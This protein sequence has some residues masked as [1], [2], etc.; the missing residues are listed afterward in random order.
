MALA[1][2][3]WQRTGSSAWVGAV[4]LASELGYIAATP[5]AGWL[6][7]RRDRRR[8][9]VGAELC[10]A[11]ISAA[12]V[13]PLPLPALV[14]LVGLASLERGAVR[15]GVAGSAADA[16]S[17][18][19]AW[20]APMRR[21]RAGAR[22]AFSPGP[23]VGG[24]GAAR[25]LGAELVFLFNSVSS[26]VCAAL[27]VRLACPAA[28]AAA[29]GDDAAHD[30]LLAGVRAIGRHPALRRICSAW[31]LARVGCAIEMTAA[32]V[33]GHE[34]G[35]GAQA[36]GCSSVRSQPAH[37][38]ARRSRRSSCGAS[39]PLPP[40]PP[41]SC[42]RRPALRRSAWHRHSRWPWSAASSPAPA[43][44][45][46]ASPRRAP[47]S[48]RCQAQCSVGRRR[49]TRRYCRRPPSSPSLPLDR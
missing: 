16:C 42:S 27:V 33:L 32:V 9:M 41:A 11:A 45:S 14:A 13:L 8:V 18:L 39:T 30:G 1:V 19:T 17:L 36:L 48:G 46:A 4:L 31:M 49:H 38:S 12:S 44:G 34:S 23:I 21:S 37:S 26:L 5:L 47:S 2:L 28:V 40:S 43:T 20:T 7:D 3:V 25:Q 6:A 35:P 10:T 22:S 29:A 15:R 24:A